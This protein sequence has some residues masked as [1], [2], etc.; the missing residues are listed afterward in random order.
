MTK[1]LFQLVLFV[2]LTSVLTNLFFLLG[3]NIFL[4]I[5]LAIALQYSLSYIYT[6]IIEIIAITKTKKIELEKLKEL[7][8]QVVEVSCPAC[9]TISK[10]FIPI[11]VT[12]PNYYKCK[13]CSRTIN[14][15]V[16]VETAIVTEPIA[17]TD[18]NFVDKII[19]EKLNEHTTKH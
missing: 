4:S 11:K 18:L 17:D 15:Y 19:T 3:L 16:A 2:L 10:E 9:P 6:N 7:S 1:Q 14:V 8:Y 12:G 5:G 13:K